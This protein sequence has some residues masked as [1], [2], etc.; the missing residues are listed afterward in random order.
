MWGQ[1]KTMSRDRDRHGWSHTEQRVTAKAVVG[2]SWGPELGCL[3]QPGWV[4]GPCVP[5]GLSWRQRGA[6]VGFGGGGSQG[7]CEGLGLLFSIQS[8]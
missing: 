1:L 3:S 6:M 2:T 8:G 4:Q 5:R 7:T